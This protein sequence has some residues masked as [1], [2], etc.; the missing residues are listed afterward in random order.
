MSRGNLRF[1]R[2][3][4]AAALAVSGVLAGI[5][6]CQSIADIPEVSF[7]PVCKD[8]CDQELTV[9]TSTDAQY[10]DY[11]TCMQVC[12]VI[13]AAAHGSTL[14]TNANTVKCRLKQLAAAKP[15][16]GSDRTDYCAAS[17]PGGGTKCVRAQSVPAP[18]CEGYCTL[19]NRACDGNSNNPFNGA[20]GRDQSG[21]LNACIDKCRAIRP[22]THDSIG[23]AAPTP[24]YDFHSGA[25]SGDTLGCRLYY[26]SLAVSDPANCDTAGIR[27]SGPCLGSSTP[28]CGD[29]CLALGVACETDELKVYETDQQCEAVCRATTDGIKQTV[30][31]VDTI[32][33]RTAHEFNALL[34]DPIA[35]CPHISP[36]GAGVCGSSATGIIG[37][38]CEA[39]CALA[40]KAC[41]GFMHE[42]MD[43]S[44]CQDQCA[45]FVG[46]DANY[47]VKQARLGGD[48][49]QC[50]TL[51]VSQALDAKDNPGTKPSV[52][53]AC[54][55]VFG[56]GPC[57]DN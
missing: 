28:D 56:R 57:V 5:L 30:D 54:E 27:P 20:I 19:Y 31:Q 23:D 15:V 49:L 55:G 12:S 26:V 50:R 29:Y 52:A 8:Y 17:G 42:Y 10:P 18:D 24:G 4:A 3:F 45:N 46:A 22:A 25:L 13:D 53:D 38:N 48:N 14:D 16:G 47:N 35:H 37:G 2:S 41:D 34:I 33:C 36:L 32:G 44:D 7:S 43:Q 39:F 40:E 9:C 21:D 1:R 11:P 51:S 6:G